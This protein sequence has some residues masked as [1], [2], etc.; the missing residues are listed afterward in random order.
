MDFGFF[1]IVD[2]EMT[3][4]QWTQARVRAATIREE[5]DRSMEYKSENTA[6][7]ETFHA[8]ESKKEQPINKEHEKRQIQSIEGFFEPT[9]RRC[10]I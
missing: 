4:D 9:K 7:L 6:T 8:L 3:I 10:C 1:C 5:Y 2:P